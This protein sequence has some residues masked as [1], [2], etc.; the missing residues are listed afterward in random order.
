M[1]ISLTISALLHLLVVMIM[2]LGLPFLRRDPP[3]LVLS[4]PV[5]VVSAETLA[6]LVET[7][8]PELD[9]PLVF[10]RTADEPP[11]PAEPIATPMPQPRPEVQPPD[12]PE[13]AALPEPR[14]PEPMP[15]AELVPEPP[16]P[17]PEPPPPEA[18]PPPPPAPLA[19]LQ[20][21]TPVE[22]SEPEP[23]IEPEPEPEPVAEPE[24]EEPP[25]P[26]EPQQVAS[27]PPVPLPERRP[28]PPPSPQPASTAEPSAA[29]EPPQEQQSAALPAPP[30][31]LAASE[32]AA[33]RDAIRDCWNVDIHAANVPAVEVRVLMRSNATVEE[34][35]IIDVDRYHADTVFRA[36]A[37]RA[38]RAVVN[39]ACQPFPL[40]SADYRAWRSILFVFDPRDMF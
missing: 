36:A 27:L 26:P 20:P 2:T 8:Q 30:T 11:P 32:E 28:T 1:P 34:A 38:L 7:R 21:E 24:P 39:P 18:A 13:T 23:V 31:R 16:P 25:P 10:D 29:E 33:V 37:D 17:E 5:E 3:D 12:L 35:T 19:E 6:E 9:E 15:A 14:E 40:P 4:M 22:P